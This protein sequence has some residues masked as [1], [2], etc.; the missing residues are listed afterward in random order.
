MSGSSASTWSQWD[1]ST[2]AVSDA[3]DRLGILGQAMR[4]WPLDPGARLVGTVFTVR[5]APVGLSG[6]TVGDYIDDVPE[7]HVVV[8]DN[9]GRED[10]TVW[11]DILTEVAVRKGLGGTVIDGIARD[12]AAAARLGYPIF[13]RGSWMRTGKDRVVAEAVQTAV[14]IG[15]VRVEPGDVLVGDRDGVVVVPHAARQEVLVTARGIEE[16]EE[17]IRGAIRDGDTLKAAR[18]RFGYHALQRRA[19]G[20]RGAGGTP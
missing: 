12:C 10:C 19:S 2:A 9:A 1:G 5:Y 16:T 20:E 4:I 15:G 14:S 3:L 17:K 13:A 8:I 11:G 6:G 18:A 7:G